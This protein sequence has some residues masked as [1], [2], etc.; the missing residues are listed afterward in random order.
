[1][2]PLRVLILLAVILIA[3]AS[4]RFWPSKTATVGTGTPAD[5]IESYYESL[6]SVDVDKYL[7]CLGE[8]YRA[9]AGQRFFEAAC[10]DAK[11]LKGLV[12]R[13]GPVEN[14]SLWVDV[15]EVRAAGVR[16]LRYHLRHDERGWGIVAIDPPRETSAPIRYGTPVGDEP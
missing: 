12:Q 2:K 11:D 13:T 16:R 10:R 7:R 5:C 8:P 15:E 1:M 9:D 4:V 3:L 14:G 6:K